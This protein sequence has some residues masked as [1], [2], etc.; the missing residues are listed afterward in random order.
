MAVTIDRTGT[1]SLEALMA[2]P[3]QGMQKTGPRVEKQFLD[4]RLAAPEENKAEK[5]AGQQTRPAWWQ[6]D[7]LGACPA[8]GRGVAGC[9]V[10]RP[11]QCRP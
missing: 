7:H 3:V 1:V 9:Q 11:L 10:W 8:V 4:H 6:Q 5:P 2:P